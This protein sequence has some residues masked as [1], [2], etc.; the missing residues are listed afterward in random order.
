MT[1]TTTA[2]CGATRREAGLLAEALRANWREME[3]RRGG[4]E[5]TLGEM[6]PGRRREVDGLARKRADLRA[7]LAAVLRAVGPV[8]LADGTACRLNAD[9]DG[10][11]FVRS[12]ASCRTDRARA[13]VLEQLAILDRADLER[14]E[15]E[16]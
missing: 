1:T 13:D 12:V 14:A 9:G 2:G 16:G 15:K 11:A 4:E 3:V 8:A 10:P 5:L 6:T 7:R